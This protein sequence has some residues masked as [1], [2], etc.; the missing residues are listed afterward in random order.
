MMIWWERE[1]REN[2]FCFSGRYKNFSQIFLNNIVINVFFTR[3]NQERADPTNRLHAETNDPTLKESNISQDSSHPGHG[4]RHRAARTRTNRLKN[5][6]YPTA[7]TQNRTIRRNVGQPVKSVYIW[8]SS[9]FCLDLFYFSPVFYAS[10]LHL[11]F[12][13]LMSVS[14]NAPIIC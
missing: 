3:L 7:V 11:K 14:E 12:V 10:Y 4:R 13:V 5:S 9:Y 6:L 8:M 2:P 1:Q